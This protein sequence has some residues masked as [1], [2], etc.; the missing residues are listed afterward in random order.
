MNQGYKAFKLHTWMP[1]I[2]WAPDP[3]M[4]V[5]A[6]AAVREAV[7]PDIP[8]MLDA[9]HYYSREQARYIGKELEKLNYHWIEEPMDEHSISSYV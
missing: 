2:S 5:K 1:P 9:F 8:L 6:C 3:R 7:G 4:D